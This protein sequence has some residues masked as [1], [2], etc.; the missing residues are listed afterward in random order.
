[1][2]VE[3]IGGLLVPIA[4]NVTVL[5]LILRLRLPVLVVTRPALGTLNHTALTVGTLRQ[6]G[7]KLAGVVINHHRRWPRTAALRSNRH[8]L[9][10]TL[11]I[12]VLAEVPFQR[13]PDGLLF[14]RLV[15]KLWQPA[16]HML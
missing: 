1:M 6:A 11:G 5:G 4:R 12:S 7:I 9:E 10:K 13:S 16:P 2:L 15:E 3:G 14:D 8:E